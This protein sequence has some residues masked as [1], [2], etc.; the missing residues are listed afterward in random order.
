MT[1]LRK[2]LVNNMTTYELFMLLWAGFATGFWW[3]ER[4]ENKRLKRLMGMAHQ[5]LVDV[6]EG[7]AEIRKSRSGIEIVETGA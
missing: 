4:E 2:C 6:S 3:N 5:V 7:K 1:N